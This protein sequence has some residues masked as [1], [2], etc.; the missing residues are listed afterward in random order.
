[1]KFALYWACWALCSGAL[2]LESGFFAHG[3]E[4]TG[5][6]TPLAT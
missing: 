2:V 5:T 6:P 1:M 4:M 3:Q